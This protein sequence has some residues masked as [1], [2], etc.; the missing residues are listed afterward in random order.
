MPA[1]AQK[2]TFQSILRE[3]LEKDCSLDVVK[4]I[5][6]GILETIN[7]NKEMHDADIPTVTKNDIVDLLSENG[8]E[9]EHIT[10]F[11]EAYDEE[12]GVGTELA[13]KNLVSTTKMEIKA[14][15]IIIH[16]NS[17][18]SDLVEAK[19]VGESKYLM[20]RLGESVECNGLEFI[21]S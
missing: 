1:V 17:A 21:I 6:N 12:F 16:I 11:A 8:V 4:T 10:A 2:E 15:D 7:T 9:E 18:R 19:T 3:T 14:P 5:Q 13:A 20:I